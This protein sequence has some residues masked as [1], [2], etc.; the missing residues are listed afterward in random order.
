MQ[1]L[2]QI[3]KEQVFS[4]ATSW[5]QFYSCPDHRRLLTQGKA[6]SRCVPLSGPPPHAR[7]QTPSQGHSPPFI[8]LTTAHQRHSHSEPSLSSS[9]RY[10]WPILVVCRWRSIS[11][12]RTIFLPRSRTRREATGCIEQE[13]RYWMVDGESGD[14]TAG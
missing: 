8:S 14:S 9:A 7:P 13:P 12:E 5:L 4:R 10:E 3:N 2:L 11:A 6:P 1:L